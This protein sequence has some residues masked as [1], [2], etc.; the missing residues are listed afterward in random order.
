MSGFIGDLVEGIVDFVTGVWLLR[1]RREA[2]GRPRNRW[3]KDAT[4]VALLDAW[5][6]GLGALAMV[7]SAIML[8]ALK[9]PVWVS[10]LP[11][12]ACL[13]YAVHRWLALSRA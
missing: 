6:L 10:L 5:L 7:A 11:M 3:S 13:V 4:D 8:F 2:K 9:L 1:R 12:A